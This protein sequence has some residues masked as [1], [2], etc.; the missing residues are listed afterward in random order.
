MASIR[1]LFLRNGFTTKGNEYP[2]MSLWDAVQV[3][4]CCKWDQLYHISGCTDD[5]KRCCHRIQLNHSSTEENRVCNG[6]IQPEIERDDGQCVELT[7]SHS[8][9]TAIRYLDLSEARRMCHPRK[10]PYGQSK[11]LR[12]KV[13]L[14]N[15]HCSP[16]TRMYLPDIS[17]DWEVERTI[18]REFSL[19]FE[20]GDSWVVVVVRTWRKHCFYIKVEIIGNW[21]ILRLKEIRL[22]RKVRS[23]TIYFYSFYPLKVLH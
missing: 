2:E 11:R 9:H 10:C 13:L 1:R 17:Q 5:N 16:S 14:P 6:F 18:I 12:K 3:A 23:I 21:K 4:K 15:H 20:F 19:V 8:F 7:A 22:D